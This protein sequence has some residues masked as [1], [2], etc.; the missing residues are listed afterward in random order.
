MIPVYQGSRYEHASVPVP[1]SQLDLAMGWHHEDEGKWD[2]PIIL[3][4][5]AEEK[6]M[7]GPFPRQLD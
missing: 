1:P 2:P 6:E 7:H 5:K 4:L 3:T